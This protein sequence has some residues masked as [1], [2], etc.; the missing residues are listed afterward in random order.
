MIG[1]TIDKA[2]TASLTLVFSWVGKVSGSRLKNHVN[3]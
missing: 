1:F 3:L 2:S